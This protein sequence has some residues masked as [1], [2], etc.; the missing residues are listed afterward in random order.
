MA[1]SR[2][3]VLTVCIARAGSE[4]DSSGAVMDVRM[5]GAVIEQRGV[6]KVF[7]FVTD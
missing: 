2:N 6:F 7:S 5:V 3:T 1:P 4:P